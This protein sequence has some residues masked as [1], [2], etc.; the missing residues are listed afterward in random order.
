MQS[1]DQD[2]WKFILQVNYFCRH[3]ESEYTKMKRANVQRWIRSVA[4]NYALSFNANVMQCHRFFKTL[5]KC[6]DWNVPLDESFFC[7]KL[8]TGL[9]LIHHHG[10]DYKLNTKSIKDKYSAFKEKYGIPKNTLSI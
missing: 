1:G 3:L 10:N 2:D 9:L 6:F 4:Q 7:R 8:F 5:F